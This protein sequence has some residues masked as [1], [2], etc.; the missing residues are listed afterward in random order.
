MDDAALS[1]LCKLEFCKATGPGGQKRNK[2]S[3]AVRATL[4]EWNISATDCTERSQTA[5]RAKALRKLRLTLAMT[6]RE[7]P[8]VPPERIDC[9][10]SHRD[11][12]LW[13]AQVLDV[14]AENNWQYRI[15]AEKL[16]LSPTA[17]LKKL[18]R[19]PLLWQMIRREFEILGLQP[20][21]SPE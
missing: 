19:D 12:P 5:N 17:F 7:T 20:L 15:A 8:A 3:S 2:T 11:Y 16:G 6:C 14:F 21:H 1:A 13:T 4:P 9:S 10:V 18:H